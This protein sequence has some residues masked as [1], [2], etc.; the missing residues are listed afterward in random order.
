MKKMGLKKEAEIIR[1][2]HYLLSSGQGIIESFSI[3]E[4]SY[5]FVSSVSLSIQSGKSLSTSI[6]QMPIKFSPI[7]IKVIEIGELTG[8]LSTSLN[9]LSAYLRH[10]YEIRS[11]IINVCIYPAIIFF[12][13]LG[14]MNFLLFYIFPKIL[15]I[16]VSLKIKLPFTTQLLIN[17]SNFFSDNFLKI[18]IFIGTI[19][20]LSCII[21]ITKKIRQKLKNALFY[22]PI[23]KTF[24]RFNFQINFFRSLGIMLQSQ[25]GILQS[26]HII[27]HNENN[28]LFNSTLHKLISHLEEGK[29]FSGFI[30]KYPEV[31]NNI[32]SQ[33]INVGERTGSLSRSCI[34]F[35]EY[36]EHD[37]MILIK[38]L[39]QLLEPAIMIFVAVI[40]GFIALSLISPLYELS[41]ISAV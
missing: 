31:F 33:F 20:G 17:L 28:T 26:I 40:V 11:Q 14:L 35:S 25:V 36:L 41:R 2:L 34:Y 4:N 7:S 15:P 16:F 18:I 21:F 6:K 37:F 13:A 1:R 8:T 38:R 10:M 23:I 29:S 9:S 24:W 22:L 39:T 19:L 27:C 5:P 32:S 3:L 12:L 30:S